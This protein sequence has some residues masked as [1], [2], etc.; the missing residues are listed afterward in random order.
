MNA[1]ISTLSSGPGL[2]PANNGLD[3]RD[4]DLWPDVNKL[5]T[6]DDTPVDNPFSEKQMR[7]LTEP[8]YSSWPGPGDGKPFRVLANVGLY[9]TDH[10]PLVPDV[11]LGLDVTTPEKLMV[12]GFRAW[13]IWIVG[14][15]PNLTLEIVSNRE[16]GEDTTKLADYAT[17][18]IPYYVIFDPENILE[19]GPLRAFA[20]HAGK[21]VAVDPGWLPGIGLGLLLWQG[22]YE[23]S[24]Q[25]W[26]RWCDQQGRLIPTGAERAGT[27]EKERDAA[28]DERDAAQEERDAAKHER[29]AA[30]HERD[31]AEE[32]RR[33][34]EQRAEQLAAKL[35]ELGHDVPGYSK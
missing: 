18:G 3:P 32:A 17:I 15:I 24:Q 30:K 7:L 33:A 26:L 21:Y 22:T 20:L 13:F 25:R 6:E 9:Q 12:K 5:V 19:K 8:L 1:P 2:H 11:M 34:A 28:Q 23:D 31:A 4:P 27:A 14:R 35:R 29:D 10:D 16:G